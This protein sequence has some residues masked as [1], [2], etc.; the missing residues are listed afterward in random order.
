MRTISIPNFLTEAV[1]YLNISQCVRPTHRIYFARE[2]F[3]ILI[4][5]EVV[6]Y[7]EE[8]KPDEDD[9]DMGLVRSWEIV[10]TNTDFEEIKDPEATRDI[11]IIQVIEESVF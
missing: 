4:N 1:A 5:D 9:A 6:N 11:E 2:G 8:Y 3:K 7:I 10:W